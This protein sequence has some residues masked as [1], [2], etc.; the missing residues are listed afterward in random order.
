M[1]ILRTL[2][3]LI[4]GFVAAL[5]ASSVG[6]MAFIV[7]PLLLFFGLPIKEAIGTGRLVALAMSAVALL[8]YSRHEKIHHKTAIPLAILFT[9]ISYFGTFI[10]KYLTDAEM[11]Y[12][13]VGIMLSALFLN[14]FSK[15]IR[16]TGKK[17]ILIVAIYT[18]LVGIYMGAFG[19]GAGTIL[20]FAP[21]MLGFTFREAIGINQSMIFLSCLVTSLVFF[22]EGWI[23]LNFAA[24]L[25][26]GVS[27]GSWVGIGWSLKKGDKYIKAL[28]YVVL[29]A[30]IIQLL[31]T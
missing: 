24:P 31:A 8:K 27:V 6:G 11:K 25:I 14:A 13:A 1:E 22:K 19:M 28:I 10:L 20:I 17:N 5:Y 2:I 26:L 23:D 30:S 3:F 4:G 15:K 9:V 12:L 21:I 18:I 7:L 29:T 16:F